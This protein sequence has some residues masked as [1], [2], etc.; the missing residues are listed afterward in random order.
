MLSNVVGGVP[1]PVRQ[2][3]RDA[4]PAPAPLAWLRPPMQPPPA[5]AVAREPAARAGA[6]AATNLPPR[7]ALPLSSQPLARR[8]SSAPPSPAV[9]ATAASSPAAWLRDVPASPPLPKCHHCMQAAAVVAAPVPKRRHWTQLV[10]QQAYAAG[11]VQTGPPP[12][13]EF[14]AAATVEG[15]ATWGAV[16]PAPGGRP[17]VVPAS[18]T[19]RLLKSP[20]KVPPLAV[21][22]WRAM[23]EQ[24]RAAGFGIPA[25]PGPPDVPDAAAA[26]S[27]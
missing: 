22:Q 26:R 3:A 1:V 2:T 24:R 18:T 10:Q 14:A 27:A 17:E 16:A 21:L 5:A 20:P 9:P 8:V 13:S 11:W 19:P 7:M 25:A 23:V 15:A 12:G 4:V 6:G